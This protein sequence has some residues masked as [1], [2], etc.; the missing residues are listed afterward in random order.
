VRRESLAADEREGATCR[1]PRAPRPPQGGVGPSKDLRSWPPRPIRLRFPPFVPAV[2]TGRETPRPEGTVPVRPHRA[3][4]NRADGHVRGPSERRPRVPDL[5][6][7]V[8]SA[9]PLNVARLPSPPP[10]G[11][12]D[13]AVTVFRPGSI[14]TS[15]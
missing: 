4:W 15:Y 9:G 3:A 11:R 10:T 5:P 12:T 14:D 1:S 8:D 7:S 6:S 13:R 2:R